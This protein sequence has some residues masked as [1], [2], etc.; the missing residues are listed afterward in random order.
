MT[1]YNFILTLLIVIFIGFSGQQSSAQRTSKI[2][3]KGKMIDFPKLP[4]KQLSIEVTVKGG[5]QYQC[6]R[7]G[8]TCT[9][10]IDRKYSGTILLDEFRKLPFYSMI[11]EP[12]TASAIAQAKVAASAREN[13]AAAYNSKWFTNSYK[14]MWFDVNVSIND[15][16]KV[17]WKEKKKDNSEETKSITETWT[18]NK[19]GKGVRYVEIILDRQAQIFKVLYTLD[20]DAELTYK[21][22]RSWDGE[23]QDLPQEEPVFKVPYVEKYLQGEIILPMDGAAPDDKTASF[24][25]T[26]SDLR[27]QEPLLKENSVTKAAAITVTYKFGNKGKN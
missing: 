6:D 7:P 19:T 3:K 22:E 8:M 18:T 25:R 15:E 9:W 13:P 27:S 16:H 12:G 1:R 5:G 17:T 11:F 24:E 26:F 20:S 2:G 23:L 14:E 10:R 4:P 21:V